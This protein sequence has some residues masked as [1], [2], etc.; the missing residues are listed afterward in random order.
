[1]HSY[2]PSR[3]NG[4]PLSRDTQDDNIIQS[5]IQKISANIFQIKIMNVKYHR[6]KSEM[7]MYFLRAK[8]SK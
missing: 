1:M 6:R 4:T 5:T 3:R 2:M 7:N 8:V